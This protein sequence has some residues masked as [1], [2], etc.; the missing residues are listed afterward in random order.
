M[1]HALRA[2]K[3][4]RRATDHLAD[5]GRAPDARASWQSRE[6][7][8]SLAAAVW[9]FDGGLRPSSRSASG[10]AAGGGSALAPTLGPA[11]L[12]PRAGADRGCG[13]GPRGTGPDRGAPDHPGRP[14]HLG[15][16]PSLRDGIAASEN[17]VRSSPCPRGPFRPAPSC[18]PAR[19]A[20]GYRADSRD[21]GH[22]CKRKSL[23]R[24]LRCPIRDLDSDAVP[25][26]PEC[27]ASVR[28]QQA[29]VKM[30]QIPKKRY[31]TAA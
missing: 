13:A 18:D 19:A 28:L 30:S 5:K 3:A 17:R 26:A 27:R 29:C 8:A 14:P 10:L 12:R 1:R 21:D 11:R 20:R 4:E 25:A 15:R 2:R 23:L 7:D 24:Y 16:R 22:H 31:D 9:R 6:D